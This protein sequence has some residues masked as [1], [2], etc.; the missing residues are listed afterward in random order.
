M[1]SDSNEDRYIYFKNGADRDFYINSMKNYVETKQEIDKIL[2]KIITPIL[3][4]SK[5]TVLDA[6]CGI[7]HVSHN[8]ASMFPHVKFFGIDQ[9]DYLINVAKD[10]CKEQKNI[11]FKNVDL[12]DFSNDNL[13]SYDVSINWKTLSWLPSY[14]SCMKSLFNVTRKHIFLS[15]LFYDGE[16]DF[17]IKVREYKKE[18]GKDGFN[19]Y[20]NIYS[21]PIFEKFLYD[22]GAKKVTSY[23]FEITKDL[24]RMNKDVMRT[25][26]VKLENQKRLQVSGAIMMPWKIIQID[27]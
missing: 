19:E 1:K 10:L 13:K 22:L 21:Y 11:S 24:P 7:G 17:E 18:G 8:L 9:T 5:V 6:C 23:D 14:R 15:S 2:D 25:Y 26:T 12:Y 27:L 3:K 4:N 16:I 20:R